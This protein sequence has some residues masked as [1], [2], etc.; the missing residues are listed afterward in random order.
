M[1][2]RVTI[3]AN[4]VPLDVYEDFD[5]K[6]WVT[7][8]VHDI[9]SLQTR[10]ASYTKSFII[11]STARNVITLGPS[12]SLFNIPNPTGIKKIPCRVLMDG[13]T[14][15]S[16]GELIIAGV[17]GKYISLELSIFWGNFDFFESL[18]TILISEVDYSDLDM[19]WDISGVTAIGENTS[20]IVFCMDEWVDTEMLNDLGLSLTTI[21]R[22]NQEIRLN[23]FW[24]YAKEVLERLVLN[25]GYTMDDSAVTWDRWATIA[26]GCSAHKWIE[27]EA[28]TGAYTG[29][30][31]KSSNTTHT[32]TDQIIA[33]PFD[34]AVTDPNGQWTG[35]ALYEWLIDNGG[36]PSRTIVFKATLNMVHT[37]LNPSSTPYVA[38]RLNGINVA[39]HN[40]TGDE[41]AVIVLEVELTVVDTDEIDCVDFASNGPGVNGSTNTILASGSIFEMNEIAGIDPDDSLEVS[42]YIPQIEAEKFVTSICNMANVIIFADE[43]NKVVRFISFDGILDSE[44]QDLSEKL[45]INKDIKSTN[46]IRSYFQNNEFKY[47]EVGNLV[48]GDVNGSYFFN[49]ELLS[50]KGTIIQLDLDACD[51]AVWAADNSCSGSFYEKE[52]ISLEGV[53]VVAGQSTFTTTDVEEWNIGDYIEIKTS[54]S[55]AEVMRITGKSSDLIGTINGDWRDTISGSAQPYFIHK[56]KHGN[57]ELARIANINQ[58]LISSTTIV[59][60]ILNGDSSSTIDTFTAQFDN[61]MTFQFLI[62]GEYS[63]LLSALERPLVI[64]AWFVFTTQEYVF[65]QQ[66]RLAYI[67]FFDSVFYINRIEQFKVGKPVRLELIRARPLS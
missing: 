67:N 52:R 61:E 48:R 27:I 66:S 36:E 33:V 53:A 64:T 62:A 40:F 12:L 29:N 65:L 23:G 1:S 34:G 8:V 28:K 44:F 16:Q 3:I 9:K 46:T 17:T 24:I 42:K 22:T 35:A 10:N 19:T 37:Q 54:G 47:S 11:P 5:E 41:T 26:L 63:K 57:F 6:F 20:G 43:A 15:L 60:G 59:D 49:D 14:V 31:L 45:A 7:R 58:D 21:T 4:D 18:R 39:I 56:H 25:A 13:I 51:N 55:W 50:A 32:D 30:V 2:T 38:I